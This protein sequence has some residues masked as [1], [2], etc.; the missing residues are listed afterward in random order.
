MPSYL[1]V[2]K[3]ENH[4]LLTAHR[5]AQAE[6]DRLTAEDVPDGPVFDAAVE[7]EIDAMDAMARGPSVSEQDLAYILER[8]T[9][10]FGEPCHTKEFGSLAIAVRAYLEQRFGHTPT[11]LAVN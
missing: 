8:Q 1:D 7:A 5:A 9:H 11:A 6:V 10:D 2:K 4:M 3:K